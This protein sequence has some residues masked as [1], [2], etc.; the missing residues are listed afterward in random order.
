[1]RSWNITKSKRHKA[2]KNEYNCTDNSM[3]LQDLELRHFK[4]KTEM[5]ITFMAPL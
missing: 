4:K 5:I 3:L 1:M 2:N